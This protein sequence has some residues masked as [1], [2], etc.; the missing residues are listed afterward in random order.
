VAAR[1]ASGLTQPRRKTRHAV[2]KR[3]KSKRYDEGALTQKILDLAHEYLELQR[4]RIEVKN[5]ETEL[6]KHR[7]ANR[8]KNG[9]TR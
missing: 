4:L 2:I 3:L 7:K 8:R 5:A 9:K 6:K 1:D